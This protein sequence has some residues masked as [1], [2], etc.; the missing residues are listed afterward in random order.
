MTSFNDITFSQS[1]NR[2]LAVGTH[3]T[4]AQSHYTT[5]LP[6]GAWS[7]SAN[8]FSGVNSDNGA[9]YSDPLLRFYVTTTAGAA[10]NA[11][12]GS[13]SGTATW[14]ALTA[15]NCPAASVNKC[16]WGNNQFMFAANSP[17][18]LYRTTNVAGTTCAAVGV[19]VFT[20]AG[21]N[22][23]YSAVDSHWV[24]VGSGTN[25]IAYSTDNGATFT[26]IGTSVFS[27]AGYGIHSTGSYDSF[28]RSYRGMNSLRNR[29]NDGEN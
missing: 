10:G 28:K 29:L 2:W 24:A 1:L 26:G 19:G 27:T 6:Y 25:T 17:N 23:G 20:T 12:G 9:C 3:P 11:I 15:G 7:A 18:T 21:N 4:T 13:T 16:E 8:G 5:S 22:V 14:A